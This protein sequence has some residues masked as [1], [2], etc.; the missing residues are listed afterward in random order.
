MNKES[1]KVNSCTSSN[2][3]KVSEYFGSEKQLLK[4]KDE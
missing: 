3:I 4:L 1:W 2:L